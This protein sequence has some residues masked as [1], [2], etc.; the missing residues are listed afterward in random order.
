MKIEEIEIEGY[1]SIHNQHLPL[2][3]FTLLIGKNNTG[4]S[5][6]VDLLSDFKQYY[7]KDDPGGEW[8]QTRLHKGD[9][10]QIS[11]G[12]HLT[13]DSEEY[14]ELL[15]SINE[16]LR[17]EY[18]QKGWMREVRVYRN[19]AEEGL[20]N[21]FLVNLDGAW[22]SSVE[23]EDEEGFREYFAN[24]L[25]RIVGESI[26]S[27]RFVAPF[28]KPNPRT[29]PAHVETMDPTGRDLIRAL[30][31]LRSS[32]RSDV[33]EKIAGSYV[34]IMENVTDI[35]I[36]YDLDQPEKDRY[37]IFVK[38]KGFE[39]RFKASEISSGSLEILVLLTQLYSAAGDS[40]ILSI[41]EPEL[42]LHPG[43]E[44]EIFDI[45]STIAQ[46]EDTQVIVTTHSEVFVD[47]SRVDNIVSVSREKDT[48]LNSVDSAAGAHLGILGYDN[49]DL[50]QSDG[51]LFV[52]GPS[53]KVILEQMARILDM[54]LSD[55]GIEVI[56]GRGDEIKNDAEPIIRVLEQLNIPYQF[57]FD[58]DGRDP[59][60]KS[61]TL[62]SE[63]GVRPSVINVLE[64]HS[65]E[66]YLI[67]SPSAIANSINAP[68]SEVEDFIEKRGTCGEP[69]GI[70]DDLYKEFVGTGYNKK[71][72]GAQIVQHFDRDDLENEIKDLIQSFSNMV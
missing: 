50:V 45:I 11:L 9:S 62:A 41:E 20:D 57:L 48:K 52:E 42:H 65:I 61:K 59:E 14:Q 24:E 6:I 4:K 7:D 68:E 28:R 27:W 16:D 23:L 32:P 8:F 36:E 60:E 22:I 56:V 2:S 64:K 29:N 54:G 26:D 63:L 51:V 34:E 12:F 66:S 70:L 5:S 71:S 10:S 19:F 55:G 53:D 25:K 47:H 37:T 18:Y 21:A 69:A 44:K 49:S 38:E 58:S 67:S 35:S 43:A 46:K 13:L 40:D 1:K 31:S 3:D 33:F 39:Q 72:N 30:E 17:D 15:Q